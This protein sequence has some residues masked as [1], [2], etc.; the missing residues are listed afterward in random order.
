MPVLSVLEVN[1]VTGDMYEHRGAAV[2]Y[3]R[4]DGLVRSHGRRF[5]SLAVDAEIETHIVGFDL[6]P[7]GTDR[8]LRR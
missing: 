6:V 7:V 3:R 8:S 5:Y 2:A 4:F 1:I